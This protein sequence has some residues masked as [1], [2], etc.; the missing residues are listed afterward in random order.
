MAALSPARGRSRTESALA[1]V[2]GSAL[3]WARLRG[4]TGTL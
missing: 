4:E 1:P 3:P 2:L